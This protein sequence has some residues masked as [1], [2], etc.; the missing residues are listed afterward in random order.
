MEK[1]QTILHVINHTLLDVNTGR[2][3]FALFLGCWARNCSNDMCNHIFIIFILQTENTKINAQDT[4]N[5]TLMVFYALKILVLLIKIV[6]YE[7]PAFTRHNIFLY[8]IKLNN[9]LKKI[10]S[11]I[12]RDIDC[13][14]RPLALIMESIFW[15][16]YLKIKSV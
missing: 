1:W 9:I 14:N 11:T 8:R 6:H 3:H 4:T 5:L 7:P 15:K 2:E 13:N 12:W 16:K 10:D